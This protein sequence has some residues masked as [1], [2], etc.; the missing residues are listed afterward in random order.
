MNAAPS[1][2]EI[3][4]GFVALVGPPNAG[5]ST[6]LNNLLGQ[7]IS[8]VSPKPQTTRN[9]VLGVFNQPTRQIVFLDTPGLHQGRSRLNS[10]MVKIA[11]RT[12][13]E[14]DAVAYMIDVSSP[15]ADSRPEQ[16]RQAGQL[17]QRANLPAL[18]LCN[19]IDQVGKEKLLPVIAAWQEVYP[20]AAIIPLSALS[21]E[22]QETLL[23]ELTRLLP[24]GPRLFPEDIPTDA[25]ERFLCG[26][27]IR[28]KIML[29]T[30]DELPYSTAVLIDR[31][32][33]ESA[34]P[35]TTI[36]ATIIV[37]KNSQ[38]GIIIGNRG[39]ML[40]QIGRSARREIE[41]MLGTKVLLK[42]WVKVQKNWTGNM[43]VLQEL[44]IHEG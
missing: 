29:L 12:V 16:R 1:P 44:G 43:R 14:V 19:K 2:D 13:S 20:F 30:R 31:F 22:G 9:R 23:D 27:I 28:E 7:K 32:R 36:D 24:R 42:L 25:S 34:P 41:A 11:R 6:L 3:T 33:E 21:G 38:K 4:C 39:R 17:L 18:L 26:E 5:K 15:E 8:I 37:E 40:Q 10:E 35:L